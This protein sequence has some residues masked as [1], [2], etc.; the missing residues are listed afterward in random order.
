MAVAVD[1]VLQ[2]VEGLDSGEPEGQIVR[3]YLET[4]S[5]HGHALIPKR[6]APAL[7]DGSDL[8]ALD[9]HNPSDSPTSPIEVEVR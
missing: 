9:S 7:H 4:V 8:T 2:E 6:F 5:N 1:V 3:V